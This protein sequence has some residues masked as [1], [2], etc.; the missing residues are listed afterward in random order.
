[1]QKKEKQQ[2]HDHVVSLHAGGL[3][4]DSPDG[5]RIAQLEAM[6]DSSPV[7]AAQRRKLEGVAPREEDGLLQKKPNESLKPANVGVGPVVQRMLH[8]QDH[9][10]VYASQNTLNPVNL[11]RFTASLDTLMGAAQTL[12]I[13]N[14]GAVKAVIG[15]SGDFQTLHN[16][17]QDPR[18]V[19]SYASLF[20]MQGAVGATERHL[21]LPRDMEEAPGILPLHHVVGQTCVIQA[22]NSFNVQAP[23]GNDASVQ[24]WHAWARGQNLDYRT[25]SDIIRIYVGHLGYQMVNNKLTALNAIN[26]A[27][28]GGDGNYL[29]S[30]YVGIPAGAAVGHMVGVVV[31]G[32]V[33]NQIHDQQNLSRPTMLGNPGGVYTRYIYRM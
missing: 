12:Q 6:I 21:L 17:F 33:I 2:R 23:G 14:W 8:R 25:D 24:A 1:M 31:N 22:L 15:I 28:L 27:N 4:M 20:H 11:P 18:N 19:F 32:G 3:S 30:T 10:R 16:Q 7:M 5:A 9:N 13:D 26:W 29:L